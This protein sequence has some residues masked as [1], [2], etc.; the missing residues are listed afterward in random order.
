MLNLL[1]LSRKIPKENTIY[2]PVPFAE[3]HTS[4]SRQRQTKNFT[5]HLYNNNYNVVFF[6]ARSFAAY[7]R[8]GSSADRRCTEV[9]RGPADRPVTQQMRKRTT[10]KQKNAKIAQKLTKNARFLQKNDKK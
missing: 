7:A 8:L 1:M 4:I 3:N 5:R 2:E 9:L 6:L 10:K